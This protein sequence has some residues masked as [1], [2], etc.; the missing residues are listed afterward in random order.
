[1][2]S[3]AG[4]ILQL[5]LLKI[6]M[7]WSVMMVVECLNVMMV[8]SS[9]AMILL[10]LVLLYH[11]HISIYS[12]RTTCQISNTLFFPEQQTINYVFIHDD[13][14]KNDHEQTVVGIYST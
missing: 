1:M 6:A 8:L 10:L 9:S 4:F 3:Y 11:H 2:F 5:R 7:K 14:Q 13:V 12:S